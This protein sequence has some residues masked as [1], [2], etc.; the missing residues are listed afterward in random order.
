AAICTAVGTWEFA[1]LLAGRGSHDDR[2]IRAAQVASLG[3][4]APGGNIPVEFAGSVFGVFAAFVVAEGCAVGELV[5][6]PVPVAA[7]VAVALDAAIAAADDPLWPKEGASH[8]ESRSI[9]A[10]VTA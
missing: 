4:A 3:S 7:A 1:V 10:S 5:A 6:V 9:A 2:W 8:A